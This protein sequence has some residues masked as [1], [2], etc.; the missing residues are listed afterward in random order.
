MK[1]RSLRTSKELN[2]TSTYQTSTLINFHFIKL[3]TFAK[4]YHQLIWTPPRKSG[5]TPETTEARIVCYAII[6]TYY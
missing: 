3:R 1:K 5:L 6:Q 4:I 2:K